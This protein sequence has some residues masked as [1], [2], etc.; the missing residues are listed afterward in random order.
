MTDSTDLQTPTRTRT[1]VDPTSGEII[2]LDATA[3]ELVDALTRNAELIVRIAEFRQALTDELAR[4][5]DKLNTRTDRI[6]P[7]DVET[8]APTEEVY[9]VDRLREE[10]GKL[11]DA[12]VIDPAVLEQVITWP[13]PKPPEPRVDKREANKLKRHPDRR[14]LAALQA[15]REIRRTKRTIK[16]KRNAIE[17]QASEAGR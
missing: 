4:R 2:P 14:V 12:D 9:S 17:G 10:L 7:F 5:L 15:A 8:N 3:P 16:I 6:G 13:T 11:V 1:A